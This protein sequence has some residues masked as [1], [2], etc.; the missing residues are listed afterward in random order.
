[1]NKPRLGR[2]LDALLDSSLADPIP[3]MAP[4]SI[5]A[6]PSSTS[7][8]GPAQVSS[9]RQLDVG[10]IDPG[11]Y[12]PRT[13][14]SEDALAELAESIRAQGIVQPLVVREK[15]GGRYELIAGERRWRAAQIAGLSVVP[16]VVRDI[17][18]EVA[19]AVALI[20]N[21]QREDLNPIEEAQ[22]IQRLMAEFELSQQ[23][24]AQ[25]VGRSRSG[26]ANLLR[27][28]HLEAAVR[29]HLELGRIDMGHARC[30]LA[31]N[32]REQ[33]DVAADVITRQ[34]NVRDTEA[35]VRKLNQRQNGAAKPKSA[36][37]PIDADVSRLID[38]VS[39]TLGAKVKL[40]D[41]GGKGR[42][43]IDYHSL[44]EL[45]GILT[46]IK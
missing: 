10:L 5:S 7:A 16:A 44:E 15:M 8:S 42:L 18:D 34:L 22:G 20:E 9:Y 2:G 37:A 3:D 1:M 36:P 19:L 24:A 21:I 31:L 46:H 14:M 30:L 41:R 12:Q 43:I 6:V 32:G 11:Q 27:L 35:L 45:D 4:Q 28:L 25:R 17:P 33:I 38:Q 13:R 29:E 40:E 26:V 23:Q 39:Q